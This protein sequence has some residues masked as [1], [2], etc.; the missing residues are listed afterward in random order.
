MRE[1]KSSSHA[2]HIPLSFLLGTHGMD[3]ADCEK[4]PAGFM[5]TFQLLMHLVAQA[6]CANQM[7]SSHKVLV[8]PSEKLFT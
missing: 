4:Q 8:F 3:L 1:H 7:N 5:R 2:S 6:S